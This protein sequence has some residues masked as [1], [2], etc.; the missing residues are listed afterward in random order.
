MKNEQFIQNKL[1]STLCSL[2]RSIVNHQQPLIR[3]VFIFMYEFIYNISYIVNGGCSAWRTKIT[4]VHNLRPI[5]GKKKSYAHTHS[6]MCVERMGGWR[7]Q[8]H[9]WLSMGIE[10][11]VRDTFQ[12]IKYL[13][14]NFNSHL[15]IFHFGI[16]FFMFIARGNQ[17][18]RS[19]DRETIHRLWHSNA[20]TYI[21][22]F[23]LTNKKKKRK[24][25]FTTRASLEPIIYLLLLTN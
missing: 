13:T 1:Q 11:F 8:W 10:R 2:E 3:K 22:Q 5:E 14:V 25:E 7:F 12:L 19:T 21:V 15:F 18:H 23:H 20:G 24:R 17:I 4:N 6:H 9:I 16:L